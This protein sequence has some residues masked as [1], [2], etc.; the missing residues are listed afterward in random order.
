[1]EPINT[2]KFIFTIGRMNPPTPGHLGLI[3]QL[4]EKAIKL[5]TNKVFIILSKTID[6]KNP[7]ACEN[8]SDLSNKKELI[9]PMVRIIKEQLK[10][11]I[12]DPSKKELVDNLR[13]ITICV[14][15]TPGAT[16]FTP[17]ELIINN[18]E[19]YNFFAG[20][21]TIDLFMII[22]EDR[23]DLLDKIKNIY[24]KKEKINNVDGEVLPREE[25]T[26]YSEM[27]CEQLSGLDIST[28]P[29][30]AFSASFVRNI[31]KCELKD[32][33]TD[34]YK[35]YFDESNIDKLYRSIEEGLKL[36]ESSTIGKKRKDL[37]KE[38][39]KK[40]SSSKSRKKGGKKENKKSRKNKIKNQENKK[41][42][43]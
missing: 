24:R 5:E 3:K 1:M 39:S 33:F 10:Y 9:D 13:V 34:I 7:L 21:S 25:M 31:V 42:R 41:S 16:P 6:E 35:P 4:I 17:I 32:K 18:T 30:N 23:A 43:K 19:P 22:G 40:E 14:P 36:K 26:I 28:V 8:E 20:I 27:T 2:N 15:S 29:V 37:S 38:S 12:I 11:T